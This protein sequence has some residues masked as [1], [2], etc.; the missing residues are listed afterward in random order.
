M[1]FLKFRKGF[2][3]VEIMI[4]TMILV[5]LALLAIPG[6]LRARHNANEAN[7]I[8]AMR[9]ISS[10]METY[11][12]GQTP[13]EYPSSFA[14]LANAVPPYLDSILATGTKQGYIY[15][16]SGGTTVYTVTA[17][18]ETVGVTGTRVFFLD[19][20]GVIRL[21]DSAGNPI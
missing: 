18:P 3:L 16:Y 2:T 4:V 8:R 12:S 11:R 14:E 21:D 6:M 7:A 5:L 20:T 19:H 17:S 9:L 13:P 1:T 15:T 10:A